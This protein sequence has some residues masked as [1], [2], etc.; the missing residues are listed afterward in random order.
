MREKVIRVSCPRQEC[1][2]KPYN[3]EE[4][5]KCNKGLRRDGRIEC[6]RGNQDKGAKYDRVNPQGHDSH[7]ASLT[8]LERILGEVETVSPASVF[9]YPA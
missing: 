9:T 6:W 4:L 1:R 2:D 5:G 8:T 7:A 3:S